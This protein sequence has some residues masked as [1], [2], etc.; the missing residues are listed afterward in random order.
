MEIRLPSVLFSFLALQVQ[1]LWI[2][3]MPMIRNE[4]INITASKPSLET[5]SYGMEWNYQSIKLEDVGETFQA[6]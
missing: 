6:S 3:I 4:D 2:S 1:E 5:S